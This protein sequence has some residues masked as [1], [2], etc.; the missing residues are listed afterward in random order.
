MSNTPKK[1]ENGVFSNVQNA[2]TN[3][4]V[5][6]G[7]T[8]NAAVTTVGNAVNAVATNIS[9]TANA[10]VKNVGANVGANVGNTS[11]NANTFANSLIPFNK[12]ANNRPANNR[13][14]NNRP[15]NNK[16][17]NTNMFV[18]AAINQSN[19]T[20]VLH[21]ALL[22][23]I[24]LLI[25]FIILYSFFSSQIKTGFERFM[26]MIRSWLG[27]PSTLSV[28]AEIV[29]VDGTT[30]TLYSSAPPPTRPPVSND[31]APD[32]T[33]VV[34]RVLPI[35][36][37]SKEVFNVAT[38]DYTYYDAEPLCKALG[39][40]LA[41]YDQVQKSWERGADWCNYG[42]V[43]GQMA[44]YPTQK[45]TY[46]RV[47][48]GPPDQK[49]SCGTVGLNGGY[50]DNPEMKMGVNCFGV[51]P[52]QVNH[53]QPNSPSSPGEVV[54]INKIN[55]YKQIADTIPINPYNTHKWGSS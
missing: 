26:N 42:W 19:K 24:S 41:N 6:V 52:D 13:P 50:F 32:V 45:E 2:V 37:G 39:A 54:E 5:N 27:M 4:A 25:I 48:N 12:P 31:S 55:Q 9:N 15:V 44:V 34:E 53:N 3:V 49:N 47:Q 7:K 22:I 38:N 18:N 10:V 16:P 29:P 23:F 33:G 43:K 30:A 11:K 35:Q 46:D 36:S 1:E 28:Q 14:E 8:A 51:K 17:I 21:P 20:G 40:E